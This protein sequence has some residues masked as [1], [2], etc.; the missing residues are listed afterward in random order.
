MIEVGD[1][2]GAL[3]LLD[4]A[5]VLEAVLKNFREMSQGGVN[6]FSKP[7]VATRSKKARLVVSARVQEDLV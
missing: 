2:V 7:I 5:V 6:V 4:I 3:G 1:D